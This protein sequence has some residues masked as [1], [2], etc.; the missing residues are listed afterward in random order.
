M[1]ELR[2]YLTAAGV[3]PYGQWFVKLAKFDRRAAAKV[4]MALIRLSMGNT[5]KLKSIG[6]GLAEIRIDFGPGYRVY[7]GRDG[8]MLIL[9][10]GGGTK[11][12]QDEDI[13]MARERWRDYRIRKRGDLCH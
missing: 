5:G 2:E 6:P 12:T 9:L 11:K 1:A 8:P 13:A 10:L 3:A 4:T 7:L